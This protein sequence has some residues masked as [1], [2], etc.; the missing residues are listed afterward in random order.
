MLMGTGFGSTDDRLAMFSAERGWR[1]RRVC[2]TESEEKGRSGEDGSVY[3]LIMRQ[4]E[5]RCQRLTKQW[6][7][8][9]SNTR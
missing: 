7:T 8:H 9:H 3:R 5:H 2:E 6:Q 1:L 4:V